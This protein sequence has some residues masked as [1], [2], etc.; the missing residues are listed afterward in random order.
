MPAPSET[1][2]REVPTRDIWMEIYTPQERIEGAVRVPAHSRCRRIAD[3][4]WHA[5][6]GAS[7]VLHLAQATV[8]DRKTSEI[9][10]HKNSLGVNKSQV[11][12]CFPMQRSAQENEP[13][14][15]IPEPASSL[16]KPPPPVNLTS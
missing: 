4:I 6:R 1:T 15:D 10:F 2:Q 7:G 11:L 12:F 8:Y 3:L 14:W 16:P 9:K 5:D 13:V